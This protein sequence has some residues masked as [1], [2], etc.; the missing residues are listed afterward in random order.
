M[1]NANT[2]LSTED[3]DRFRAFERRRHNHL[4]T[5]YRD[6]FTPVTALAVRFL[7]DAARVRPGIDLLDVAT[8]PGVIAAEAN[9]L[10]IR[11]TAIDLSLGMIELAKNSYPGIEF[12]VADVEHLPFVDA[13][14][15]AV[16]CNFRTLQHRQPFARRWSEERKRTGLQRVSTCRSPLSLVRAKSRNNGHQRNRINLPCQFQSPTGPYV[17]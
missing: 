17:S 5:T 3:A 13:S 16:V 1:T 12:H 4:A 10:G 6:F 2:S 7:L 15:D 8:G 11:C 9:S 14:F